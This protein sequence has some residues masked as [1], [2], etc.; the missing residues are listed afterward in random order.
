MNIGIEGQRLFRPKKHGMDFVALELVRNIQH[1]DR[2]NNYFVFVKPDTDICLES[3]DNVKII[4]LSGGP[5][6]TWEQFALPLAAKKCRCDLLH[7]TSNTAPLF[8]T[9][10]MIVTV[11]DI[12]YLENISLFY[13]GFSVYQKFGNMYRRYDVPAAV[14]RARRVVTVSRSEKNRI[15][16]FFRLRDEQ[17]TVIYN[18]VSLNFKPVKDP[19]VLKDIRSKYSLPEH[20]IFLFGNTD[21]K[22]NTRGTVIAFTKYLRETQDQIPLVIA[23]YP[24]EELDRILH[25]IHTPEIRRFIHRL[26]YIN[27]A[28]LPGIYSL[29]DLFIYPSFRESFGIPILEAM[30]CGT[31]VITSNVFAMP[32][33]AGDAAVL[34]DPTNPHD[35]ARAMHRVLTEPG[36]R[37]G[38]SEKGFRQAARF[39]W[40]KMA[41]EYLDLYHG[42]VSE[43]KRRT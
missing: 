30:A 14:K 19:S 21:P 8:N 13:K 12:F 37:S 33:V 1:L 23:D 28:D 32:E 35:M 3:T 24:E 41:G 17:V 31:P 5:Y 9:V 15:I 34:A 4:P 10:P 20:F 42:I 39:S 7:C 6:P 11:H 29:A 27:N 38:L 16:H 43:M 22:K 36:L 18:G 26:D 2:E 40:S 25:E